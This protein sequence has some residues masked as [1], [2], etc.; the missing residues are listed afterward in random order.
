M[1]G[2]IDE[3]SAPRWQVVWARPAMV[4]TSELVATM[5]CPSTARNGEMSL[6][7]IPEFKGTEWAAKSKVPNKATVSSVFWFVISEMFEQ[8]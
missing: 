7:G 8:F 4:S 5:G 6:G 2:F 1:F 3:A